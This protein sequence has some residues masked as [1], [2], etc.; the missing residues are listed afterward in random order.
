MP[1]LTQHARRTWDTL[2]LSRENISSEQRADP[3]CRK[4]IR[5]LRYGTLPRKTKEARAIILREEDYVMM[6][7]ILFHI[8]TPTKNKHNDAQA[9]LVVPQNLKSQILQHHHDGD[10]AGHIGISRMTSVMRVRFFWPGMIEDIKNYVKTCKSCNAAKPSNRTIR[11][12]MTIR[13]PAPGPFHT[14]II[15]TVGPLVRSTKKGNRHLVCVTDQYSRWVITWPTRDITAKSLAD[16]FY[17]KVILKY[18]APKRLLSDNGTGFTAA[19]FK[20]LCSLL[21]IKQVFSPAY[22]PTSQGQ[23]ERAQRSLILL[24]KN[25]VN[26]KQDDWDQYLEQVTWALNTS[27]NR[28]LGYSSYFMVFG[29]LPTFPS[30]IN[31]PDPMS[32]DRTTFDHLTSILQNQATASKFAYDNL[33]T[34]QAHMKERHDSRATENKIKTGDPVYV[35]EPRLRVKNTK[36]KLQKSFAGPYVVVKYTNPTSVQLKRL[37][38]GKILPKPVTI[39]RLK[40]GHVRANTNAWDPLPSTDPQPELDINDIPEHNLVD[41]DNTIDVN[42]SQP[43]TNT[44]AHDN[45]VDIA[46]QPVSQAT[47]HNM[48]QTSTQFSSQ[49]SNIDN[50]Q[51]SLNSTQ[52]IQLTQITPTPPITVVTP[53]MTLIN[54]ASQRMTRSQT[55]SQGPISQHS[56]SDTPVAKRRNG[57]RQQVLK[58]LSSK[59]DRK[60]SYIKYNLEFDK[61]QTEW[62]L[63]TDVNDATLRLARN[64]GIMDPS[65]NN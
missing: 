35:Y 24:L 28:P 29:R 54:P 4:I 63:S 50:T 5:F 43:S 58:V 3:F 15:D 17:H 36:K 26:S 23:V 14:L 22:K 25:F 21:H 51:S 9:Q 33:A 20:E 49:N 13:E 31:L 40:R 45:T 64:S 42:N 55:Q 47:S 46:D 52:D 61:G 18:G 57:I 16:D 60:T 6:N 62:V 12:E 48:T 10:M 34:Q 65:L 32:T 2:D 1:T 44:L 37:S 30:E 11:P 39:S 27:E 38:D 53:T 59:V 19:L 41:E 7:N 56:I 8:Y